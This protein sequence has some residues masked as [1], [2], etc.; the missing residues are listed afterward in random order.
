MGPCH[1]ESVAVASQSPGILREL[2]LWGRLRELRKLGISLSGEGQALG[3]RGKERMNI[4][5]P[6]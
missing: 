4:K 2:H 3:W 5:H 6:A 1:M